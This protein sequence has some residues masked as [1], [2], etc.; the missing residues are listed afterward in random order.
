M[1]I[2]ADSAIEFFG[3]QD[4]LDSTSGTVADAAF[5]VAGDLSEWTNDDD[6][7]MAAMVLE[8]AFGTAPD[9]NSTVDLYAQLM[10]IVSTSD[11]LAPDANNPHVYLGSF[12]LDD[13]TS[14]QFI[15]LDVR[16]PNT[17]TSQVYQFYVQNNGGQT[18][19]AGWDLHVTPKTIG[20]HA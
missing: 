17:A 14:T 11:A 9:A 19:S 4:S 2:G 10:N 15:P 5:S 16:L 3:T 8:C 13:T 12:P 1:A 20:P 6:A 18:M 7:P